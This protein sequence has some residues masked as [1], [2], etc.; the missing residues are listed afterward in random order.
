VVPLKDTL[1]E[2]VA[3]AFYEHWVSRHGVPLK[4]STNRGPQ[5]RSDLFNDLCKF[6]GTDFIRTTAYNPKANGI[7]ER[8]H[9]P[10]KAACKAHGN[11]WL[12][13]L[14]SV[15]LGLRAAPKDNGFSPAEMTFGRSLV[16]PGELISPATEPADTSDF[17]KKLR[18][19]LG[20]IASHKF[21]HKNKIAIFVP[22]DLKTSKKVYVRVDRVRKPAEAPYKG[23]YEVVKRAKKYFV[24]RFPSGK[25]DTISIDRLKPAYL[26]NCGYKMKGTP[27]KR[28]ILKGKA[29]TGNKQRKV[30]FSSVETTIRYTPCNVNPIPPILNSTNTVLSPNNQPVLLPTPVMNPSSAITTNASSPCASFSL[31]QPH[32]STQ[33]LN[34]GAYENVTMGAITSSPHKYSSYGRKIVRPARFR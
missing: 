15:L 25:K 9:R 23:P 17:I 1:A 29:E 8:Y 21:D 16:L 27:E 6:L 20:N 22:E 12:H 33:P 28:T 19:S 32:A 31:F 34:F 5:F 11:Q 3:R 4:L 18:T 26:L 14:P 7:L 13:A 10:L 2:T 24:V 30:T